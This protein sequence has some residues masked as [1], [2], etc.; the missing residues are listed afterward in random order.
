V[1]LFGGDVD[2]F[3][4]AQFVELGAFGGGLLHLVDGQDIRLA[5]AANDVGDLVVAGGHAL[6]AVHENHKQVGLAQGLDCLLLDLLGEYIALATHETA[7]VHGNDLAG[8]HFALCIEPVTRDAWEVLHHCE[9]LADEAVEE[10]G[11]PDVHA[12]DDCDDW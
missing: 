7:G 10:S 4:Q 8:V 3:T 2:G 12:P 5:A 1:A 6:T 9:L 11:F